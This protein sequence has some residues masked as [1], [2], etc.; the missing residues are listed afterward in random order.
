MPETTT[1]PLTTAEGAAPMLLRTT[2]DAALT[3]DIEAALKSA[4]GSLPSGLVPR[5]ALISDGNEN[6]GSA[7]RAAA[8]NV[9]WSDASGGGLAVAKRA[10]SGGA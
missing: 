1:R 7:A 2:G 8:G 5:V 10:S 6:R 9:A 4:L 3:T